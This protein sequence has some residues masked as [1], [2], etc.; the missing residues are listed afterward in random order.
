HLQH[1]RPS[2]INRQQGSFGSDADGRRSTEVRTAANEKSIWIKHRAWLDI[3]RERFR[4]RSSTGSH[5]DG[6]KKRADL[7]YCRSTGKIEGYDPRFDSTDTNFSRVRRSP[8]CTASQGDK[9]CRHS[10]K[11]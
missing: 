10:R 5:V 11:A 2:G 4:D 6:I 7:R 1:S 8:Y 9:S 3:G